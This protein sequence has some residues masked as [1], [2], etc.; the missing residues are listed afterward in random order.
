MVRM[1]INNKNGFTLI[2]MIV[3]ILIVGILSG[4]LFM[5]LRGPMQA[6]VDVEKRTRLVDIAD[7]ALQ[8]MTREIRLA[9]PNSIQVPGGTTVEFLR[10]LDGGRYRAKPGGAGPAVCGGP[11][12]QDRLNFALATDCF[13]V[14]GTLTNFAS[15]DTTGNCLDSS[16][17]CLVIYNTGQLNA[18]AYNGDNVADITG[19]TANSITFA[20]APPFP[21]RSPR[22]RFFVVDTPV[23]FVCSVGN[24]EIRREDDYTL[25][26]VIGAGVGDLLVNQVTA[27]TFSYN[28]GSATRAGLVTLSITIQ[29]TTLAGA[30]VTL[31]Q[32]VHVDNQP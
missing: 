4:V 18:D 13:E 8:R 26:T 3:V 5:V 2:E 14:M 1:K 25:G 11:V 6:F 29:D 21:F 20:N 31:L 19:A 12:A 7:T 32:Q 10:T 30:S 28:A 9:L 16:S 27:C 15:I 22:Q 17:D 23:S 24:G